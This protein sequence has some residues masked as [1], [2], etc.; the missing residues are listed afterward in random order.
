MWVV[1][2]HSEPA[3]ILKSSIMKAW[4]YCVFSHFSD[5]ITLIEIS[6][7]QG[8]DSWPDWMKPKSRGPL[9]L[10]VFTDLFYWEKITPPGVFDGEVVQSPVTPAPPAPELRAKRV[11]FAFH[12]HARGPWTEA[13]AGVQRQ[14]NASGVTRKA[15]YNMNP[16]VSPPSRRITLRGGVTSGEQLRVF[17]KHIIFLLLKKSPNHNKSKQMLKRHFAF[18]R[19]SFMLY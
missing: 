5:F 2:S 17:A 12:L 18:R 10:F 4:N 15:N 13:A 3:S 16:Y 1:S 14:L 8:L 6:L 7:V 19:F 11:L 9:S